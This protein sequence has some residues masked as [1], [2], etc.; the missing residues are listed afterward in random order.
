MDLRFLH[1][2]LTIAYPHLPAGNDSIWQ[3]EIPQIAETRP[4]LM[5]A[6]LGLGGSHLAMMSITPVK[7]L[8]TPEAS[9]ATSTKAA[10]TSSLSNI[11]LDKPSSSDMANRALHHR[12][13]A[14]SGL[15]HAITTNDWSQASVD[16]MLATT[17]ALTFQATYL[18]DDGMIDFMTMVR[19][20]ALITSKIE[21]NRAKSTFALDPLA[22][23]N[24]LQEKLGDSTDIDLGIDLVLGRT[25]AIRTW[26]AEGLRLLKDVHEL[27][28]YSSQTESVV[29]KRNL[30][31][32]IHALEGL[33]IG[34]LE[35]WKRYAEIYTVWWIC[36]GA[37]F[38]VLTS[39][40]S[41]RQMPANDTTTNVI[42][43]V[44][45]SLPALLG[46]TFLA[47]DLLLTPIF[48][49]IYLNRRSAKEALDRRSL[50]GIGWMRR[51][52]SIIEAGLA[53]HGEG[54]VMM[55]KNG[56]SLGGGEDREGIFWDGQSRLAEKIR[57][58]EGLE[59]L[60][61]ARGVVRWA[62]E[63]ADAV[64]SRILAR[65]PE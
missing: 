50:V 9:L 33:E 1:H 41:R 3:H 40:R 14:L 31:A 62:M 39:F 37:E 49:T 53:A 10:V 6:L 30:D 28:S 17:Y 35:A 63:L 48:A 18:S 29:L 19:G 12:S 61:R 47:L 45:R 5:H 15:N 13:I 22:H 25:R 20:C 59:G 58:A 52:R 60:G 55:E 21:E 44:A 46:L 23:I 8:T 38:D 51:L 27:C 2:F 24:M 43:D 57:T 34:P 54:M 11:D 64:E 4:Y 26:L 7:I 56:I 16:A 36:D 32:L 65:L 42:Q